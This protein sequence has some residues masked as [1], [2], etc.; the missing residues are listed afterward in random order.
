MGYRLRVI[1]SFIFCL[2]SFVFYL[3]GCSQYR[4]SDDPSL[5][6][7]FSCDTL[8]FDTVFT[9]EGSSTAQLMVYNRNKSAIEIARAGLVAGTAFRINIDGEA[10]PDYMTNIVINGEDSAFVFIRVDI[11]PLQQNNPI[12][13]TGLPLVEN[14]SA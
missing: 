11:D 9:A 1:G 3:T 7:S 13:I 10:D 14:I 12:L 4:V 6:L 2:L 5:R 8:S